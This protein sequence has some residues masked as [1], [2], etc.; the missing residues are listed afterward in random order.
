ME[1]REG[2]G[3][4]S[5]GGRASGGGGGG[6]GVLGGEGVR[7]GDGGAEALYHLWLALPEGRGSEEFVAQARRHG[8]SV[9]SADLFCTGPGPGP[10]AVRVCI[11]SPRTRAQ[12]ARGLRRLREVM[13]AGPEPQAAI[14]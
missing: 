11:G 1:R 8:V 10:A 14:V 5:G 2:R 13:D 3:G 4:A 9:T 6:G 7:G 12:L